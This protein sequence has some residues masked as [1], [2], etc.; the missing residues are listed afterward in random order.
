MSHQS[1]ITSRQP[2]ISMDLTVSDPSLRGLKTE[3]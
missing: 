3:D 2:E 1:P